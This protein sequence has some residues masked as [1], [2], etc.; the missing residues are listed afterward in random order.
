MAETEKT[1]AAKDTPEPDD[2]YKNLQRQLGKSQATIKRLEREAIRTETQE[3][4]SDLALS[5]MDN[6]ITA[7]QSDDGEVDLESVRE[8]VRASKATLDVAA[9]SRLA[10]HDITADEEIEWDTDERL[11]DARGLWKS[12]DF[13]GAKESAARALGQGGLTTSAV[14]EQV[15]ETIKEML[16]ESGGDIRKAA[17]MVDQSSQTPGSSTPAQVTYE[18]LRKD[19]KNARAALMAQLDKMK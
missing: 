5:Q 6:L 13:R 17:L 18:D 12:G 2:Q 16:A 8:S 19:P 14:K 4:R 9:D 11:E 7:L 1:G 15:A 3:A 10:I